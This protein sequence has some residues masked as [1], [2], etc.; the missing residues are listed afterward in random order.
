MMLCESEV[1]L[2]VGLSEGFVVVDRLLLKLRDVFLVV[3][4]V[5]TDRQH[6]V[7]HII[8]LDR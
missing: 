4:V 1:D 7:A 6:H 8:I 5:A 2:G 3:G